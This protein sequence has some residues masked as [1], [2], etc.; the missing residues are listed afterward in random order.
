MVYLMVTAINNHPVY[1]QFFWMSVLCSYI[2]ESI[3]D[4]LELTL[5]FGMIMMFACAFPSIFCFAALVCGSSQLFV[6]SLFLCPSLLSSACHT[7][8]FLFDLCAKL[9]LNYFHDRI[10]W[11]KLER[12]HWSCWSCW[13]DLLPVMQLRL[14]LGWTYSRFISS[15][16]NIYSS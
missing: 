8:V 3:T 9:I 11:L 6:F 16:F 15:F 2:V 5:Q 1:S 13:K 14:E 4:F 12:M 10:M 7:C